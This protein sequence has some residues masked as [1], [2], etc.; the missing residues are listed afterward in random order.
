M[1]YSF[2]ILRQTRHYV[3][4]L[5]DNLTLEQLNTIPAGFN[6]NIIWNVA[7]LVAT[8]QSICYRRAG[9]PM[10]VTDNF[11]EAYKP[12]SKPGSNPVSQ[13]EFDDI[14]ALLI[15]TP[16]QLQADYESGLLNNYIDPLTTRYGVHISN[17]KEAITFL[18]FHEGMH[19]GVI[20][21]QR[22]LV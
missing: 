21:A 3:L 17:I 5:I 19:V 4:T 13:Q 20:M 6:N 1:N 10:H 12:G 8:Q 2:D 7:H 16:D 9:Q 18:P 14:K 22:K 15:S 11:F